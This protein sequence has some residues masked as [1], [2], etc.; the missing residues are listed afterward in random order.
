M[1]DH[2]YSSRPTSQRRPAEFAA[3]LGGRR[4]MLRTD[5]G[6]FSRGGI[7]RGTE[8]LLEALVL[9][10]GAR[11]LVDLGCGY[12]PIGLAMAAMAPEARVYMIDPN[13]RA[14]ELARANACRNGLPNIEVLQGEGLTLVPDRI[15]LIATNPPIRA[16]KKVVY[17]LM[18]EAA[19]RLAAGG[20]LW[21]VIRTSQGAKSLEAE[22]RLLFPEVEEVEKGGGFRVYRGRLLRPPLPRP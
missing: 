22:L 11:V 1:E 14:C 15:D 2:Y 20:E 12:G 19:G 4:M 21:T 3:V 7:D 6:V 9:P 13:E 10:A 5:A 18:R 8:L 17:G 16:G